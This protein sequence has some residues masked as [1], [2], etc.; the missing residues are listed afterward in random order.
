MIFRHANGTT[1]CRGTEIVFPVLDTET[2]NPLCVV[3]TGVDC[4]PKKVACT[5]VMHDVR[6]M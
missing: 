3:I 6:P 5:Y 2:K 4:L 1:L